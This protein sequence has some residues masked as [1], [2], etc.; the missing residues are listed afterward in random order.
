[1]KA[2]DALKTGEN[3]TTDE[4]IEWL[5]SVGIL[6]SRSG[7]DHARKT[8]RLEWLKVRGRQRILYTR[9]ALAEAFFEGVKKCPSNLPAETTAAISTSEE[10]SQDSQ[11]TKALALATRKPPKQS[12]FAQRR[13]CSNVLR[14][15][16]KRQPRSPKR[17]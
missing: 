8:G 13:K 6:T 14:L 1:M 17:P 2:L 3:L 4:A 10:Q 5:K 11:F 12:A 9:A 15:E 7:L 16:K